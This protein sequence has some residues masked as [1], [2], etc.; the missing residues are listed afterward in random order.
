MDYREADEVAQVIYARAC[1]VGQSSERQI[2]PKS[3]RKYV[4]IMM[5]QTQEVLLATR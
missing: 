4:S 5:N 1:C 3:K 2:R